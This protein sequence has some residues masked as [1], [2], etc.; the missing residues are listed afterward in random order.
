MGVYGFMSGVT[1]IGRKCPMLIYQTP[2][3]NP[4]FGYVRLRRTIRMIASGL[5]RRT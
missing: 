2:L 1:Y 5:A 3:G 4:Q